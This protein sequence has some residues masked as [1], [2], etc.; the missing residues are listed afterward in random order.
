M[1]RTIF[2]YTVICDESTNPPCVVDKNELHAKIIATPMTE[3]EQVEFVYNAIN[4]LSEK[5]LY[6]NVDKLNKK[7]G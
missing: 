5:E 4:G 3:E 6:A 7:E 2:K 1:K